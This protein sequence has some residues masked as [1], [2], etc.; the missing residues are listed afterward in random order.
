MVLH[1]KRGGRDHGRG[2]GEGK[3]R[4]G[5]G[6]DGRTERLR[7]DPKGELSPRGSGGGGGGGE[8]GRSYVLLSPGRSDLG[9]VDDQRLHGERR[10]PGSGQQEAAFE[11][12]QGRSCWGGG[13]GGGGDGGGGQGV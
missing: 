7:R 1:K 5:G 10:G 11:V 8:G 6:S 12:G 13:Q 3:R 4:G 2:E 9:G